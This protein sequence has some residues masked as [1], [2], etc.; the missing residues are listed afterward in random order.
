M[1]REAWHA[2]VRGV[3][4]SWTQLSDRAKLNSTELVHSIKIPPN[5]LLNPSSYFQL[6]HFFLSLGLFFSLIIPMGFPGSSSG[7]ESTCNTGN[8]GSIPELRGSPGG[9]HGN[10]LQYSCLESHRQ[11]SQVGYSS[12]GCKESDATEWLSTAQHDSSFLQSLL[13]SSK[14][15]GT[16]GKEPV[17]QN[18]RIW[19]KRFI[20]WVGKL[21]WRRAW[22]PT[23]V[24]LP[25]KSHGQTPNRVA[26]TQTRLKQFS[27]HTCS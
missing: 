7:K 3:A 16:R 8:P 9:G 1:D 5:Y 17:H 6:G 11:R 15:G 12:L 14:A 25:G 10:P 22:K 27:T 2:A 18:R 26:K 13:Y 19:R 23:P 4:K 21:P 24:F 20:P